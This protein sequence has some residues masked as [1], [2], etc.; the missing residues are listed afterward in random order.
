MRYILIL[1][2]FFV[3][4][5]AMAQG[6]WQ[7]DPSNRK[8]RSSKSDS[9][10]IV[11]RDTAAQN[12]MLFNGLPVGDSGRIA[13]KDGKFWGHD[14]TGWTVLGSH[15]I[16]T[17][18]FIRNGTTPQAANYN[19]T[20]NG[21]IGN[22][23]KIA[24][25]NPL[26]APLNVGTLPSYLNLSAFF[27]G[28]I[29]HDPAVNGNEGVIFSQ[30]QD[31]SIAQNLQRVTEKGNVTTLSI[32]GRK[33]VS[34]GYIP[35]TIADGAIEI[36]G[37]IN[38]GGSTNARGF[39]DN[40]VYRRSSPTPVSGATSGQYS[41]ASA[42]MVSVLRGA[43]FHHIVGYQSRTYIDVTGKANY[44][45]G[46]LS[47]PNITNGLADTVI[48][49]QLRRP[50]L[51]PG[52][53]T[54]SFN[55][56]YGIYI[57]PVTAGLVSNHAI[58]SPGTMPSYFGGSIDLASGSLNLSGSSSN[59]VLMSTVGVGAPTFVTRSAGTKIALWNAVG[60]ISADEALGIESSHMWLSVRDNTNARGFKF[61]GGTT[62]VARISGTG[63]AIFGSNSSATS[64][65]QSGGSFAANTTT[66]TTNTTLDAS[67]YAVRVN[68]SGTATIG[69]PA[70]STCTGRIYV[71]TKVSGIPDNIVTIDPNGSELIN[72]DATRDL[73]KENSSIMIQSFGTG[74]QILSGH[75][76]QTIY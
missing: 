59:L 76:G 36:N 11:P 31:S 34:D 4:S 41:Y 42:D 71:I 74:W 24:T 55:R 48:G 46:F 13:Y 8:M 32:T 45:Y 66:V 49:V 73:T 26:A 22:T 1:L 15:A 19:I 20:G 57:E 62:Q 7:P 28:T 27:E 47:Q 37:Q 30:L 67:H 70:A 12:N 43:N 6:I 60:A 18:K 35:P 23:L 58:Y 75:Q 65:L 33:L 53:G 21:T 63:M 3:S 69:L 2:T 38:D 51:N 52:S 10:H 50:E 9:V 44:M 40:W 72:G 16:D 39:R 29:Q 54:A 64:T 5:G 61:Y 17:T 14:D 68:N 56:Y 25:T